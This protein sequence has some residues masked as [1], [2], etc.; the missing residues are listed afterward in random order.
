MATSTATG[1]VFWKVVLLLA[2]VAAAG[3]VGTGLGASAWLKR[4]LKSDA[5]L[6][7]IEVELAKRMS[8]ECR[9][10]P[11]QWAGYRSVYT[12]SIEL[13]GAEG[14]WFERIAAEGMRMKVG[15]EGLRGG[16]VRVEEAVVDRLD[17]R[18]T[19]ERPGKVS[20]DPAGGRSA[21]ETGFLASFAPRSF[22][23]QR[24]EIANFAL[25]F[26]REET[27]ALSVEGSHI[28]A[29]PLGTHGLDMRARGGWLK[30]PGSGNLELQSASLRVTR[31]GIFLDDLELESEKFGPLVSSGKIP[32]GGGETHI[33]CR[34]IDMDLSKVLSESFRES[35]RGTV[36]GKLTSSGQAGGAM[37]YEGVVEIV[38][39]LLERM[40]VLDEIA[41]HTRTDRFR[42]LPLDVAK[43]SFRMAGDRLE[44]DEIALSADGLIRVEGNLDLV[45]EQVNGNFAV[46]VAPA[47]LRWIPGAERK[48]FTEERDGLVWTRMLVG[49]T[50]QMPEEDLS[51]RLRTASIVAT[52]EEAPEKILGTA[53][54][55]AGQL[56]NVAGEVLGGLGGR[57]EPETGVHSEATAGD[58]L[59]VKAGADKAPRRPVG[60]VLDAGAGVL[61]ETIEFLPLFR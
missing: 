52:I 21:P 36:T 60:R 45:G 14:A 50:R 55:A 30:M 37:V 13:L 59:G 56:G 20:R 40:T 29:K 12:D 11:L 5:L 9:M 26:G 39:G 24:V 57:R 42:R 31:E 15:I 23:W 4:Y 1:G 16:T 8:A 17:L 32:L 46:G 54:G 53:A 43:A 47:T 41:R 19:Q 49:G 27:S 33:D 2:F 7:H 6:E 25:H 3:V 44:I 38:D 28:K 48:V 22:D 35:I 10:A 58:D 51:S 61:Q 18:V 34:V